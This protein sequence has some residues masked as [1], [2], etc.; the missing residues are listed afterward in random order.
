MK[1][2]CSKNFLILTFYMYRKSPLLV[3]GVHTLSKADF[4]W[5]NL[6][7]TYSISNESRPFALPYRHRTLT[8]NITVPYFDR[9]RPFFNVSL[10]I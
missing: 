5:I 4:V 1:I 6:K 9:T 10:R 3:P 2:P 8:I 7:E